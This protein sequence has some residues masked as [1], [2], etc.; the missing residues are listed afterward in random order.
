MTSVVTATPVSA[1]EREAASS[2]RAGMT[3]VLATQAQGSSRRACILQSVF[4]WWFRLAC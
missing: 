4:D 3:S 2:R 1:L